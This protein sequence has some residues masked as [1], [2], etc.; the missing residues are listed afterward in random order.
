VTT[1]LAAAGGFLLAVLWMDLLFDVQVLH[2]RGGADDVPEEA[3]A[4]IAAYYRR[5]TT[6]ARPMSHLIGGVMAA[7]LAGVLA[8]IASG[9][10]WAGLL[11]LPLCAGAVL[12]AAL[13]VLPNAVRLGARSDGPAH[14]RALARAICRDHLLCLAAI[15]AFVCVQLAAAGGS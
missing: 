10:R 3:V 1:F 13:R 11:S 7:T 6:E 5:V 15:A 2:A 12:L 8:E 14:Q 9:P 4:S